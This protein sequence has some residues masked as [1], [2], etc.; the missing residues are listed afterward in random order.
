M[1]WWHTALFDSCSLITLDKMIQVSPGLERHFPPSVTVIKDSLEM[2]GVY[3][4]TISRL[5]ERINRMDSIGGA[6][7][8]NILAK[9][10]VPLGL[11]QVDRIILANAIHFK[12][13]VV[14]ADR[15]MAITLRR[16]GTEVSN[17]ALLL[18][19]FVVEKFIDSR[20]VERILQ[21][22]A[23]RGEILI[24]GSDL[25]WEALSQYEFPRR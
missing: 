14:T 25:S 16:L 6:V 11:S 2:D 24:H 10:Q 23:N 5:S 21:E 7:L 15:K 9:I 4:A 1:T 13:S 3:P 17:M 8:E 22:L 20:E 12:M 19:G 18:K